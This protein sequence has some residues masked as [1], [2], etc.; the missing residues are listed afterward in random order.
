MFNLAKKPASKPVA[1]PH[2]TIPGARPRVP[3]IAPVPTLPAGIDVTAGARGRRAPAEIKE[4]ASSSVG[5]SEVDPNTKAE[6]QRAIPV[7]SQKMSHEQIIGLLAGYVSL[8]KPFWENMLAYRQHI[9]YTKIKD[10][11]FVRGGFI[12]GIGK[13][14][15]KTTLTLAN[16]FDSK[17]QGYY[18]WMIGLDSIAHIFV[19]RDKPTG[20]QPEHPE[21]DEQP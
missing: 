4:P 20:G 9:R 13:Q 10:N 21:T 17:R 12:V 6:T 7:S 2:G 14:R 5:V 19:K 8:P 15:G 3:V 11:V 1:N 18:C 16:G